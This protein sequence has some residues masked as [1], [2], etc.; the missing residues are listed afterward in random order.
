MPKITFIG[1]GSSIFAKNI[2]GDCMRT[3]SL[4]NAHMALYDINDERLGQSEKM[5]Q[6]LNHNLGGRATVKAYT[7]R[8]EALRGADY[9]INAIAVGELIPTISSDF[10]IPEKYGLHQTVADTLGM[11]GLFRGLRT[12]PV[13]LDMAKDMEEVCPDAW[14]L[15]YTNPMAIVTGAMQQATGIKTVGLCHSVQ[16]CARELLEGLGMDHQ[17]VRW[18]IGGINHQ[19]WLL[20]ITRDGVDLY[21]EIR[22]KAAARTERHTDMVR[23]DFMKLF[24]YFVTESSSH[25]SEYVPYYHKHRYPELKE[26]YSLPTTGYKNWG[27]GKASFWKEVNDMIEN[28]NLTHE[29]SHEY[30][31]YIME[32]M[33]TN[34]PFEI[35]GNVLNT[36]GLIGNLPEKACV[37]VPC[38]VNGNGIL[39]TRFGE[40]PPQCAALNRTNINMQLLT[41]EA[42]ITG[43]REHV[44]HAAMLDPHTSSELS[45]DDIVKMC[46][47]MLEANQSFLSYMKA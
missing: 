37:E 41:I 15:N 36:G 12:I 1:A 33:E 28:K 9:V 2:L 39:P 14:L 10:E 38:M 5:L 3:P 7:D 30:A 8:K 45:L 22:R 31:S 24:G 34:V 35:A 40:L 47:E 46:D 17:D 29:R 25:G 32:A 21:P 18:R 26:K 42:A 44:Y 23:Y 16:T 27:K 4:E 13:M 11:G 43:K 19:A 6:N 20:E